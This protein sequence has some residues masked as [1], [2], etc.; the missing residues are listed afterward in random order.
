MK[1]CGDGERAGQPPPRAD[2]DPT[3]PSVAAPSVK[4]ATLSKYLAAPQLASPQTAMPRAAR[5]GRFV[6]SKGGAGVWHRIIS[7]MPPH[8]LYIEAFAGTGQVLLHKRPARASIAIDSDAAVCDA[9]K[10]SVIECHALKRSLIDTNGD[11]AGVTILCGDAVAWL[12]KHR[13]KF[14]GQTLVTATRLT[15]PRLS[16]ILA[17]ITTATDLAQSGCTASCWP[18]SLG[19]ARKMCVCSS[20]AIARASTTKCWGTGA[21]LTTAPRHAAAQSRKAFGAIS[22]RRPSSTTTVSSGRASASAKG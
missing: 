7:E 11:G 3:G 13:G 21:G 6:G 19:S 10:R 12:E 4:K 1:I 15:W 20:A 16:V 5:A 17:G 8:D 2:A 9:L 14:T 18:C 22:T